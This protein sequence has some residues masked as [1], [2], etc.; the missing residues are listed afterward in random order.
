MGAVGAEGVWDLQGQPSEDNVREGGDDVEW[1]GKALRAKRRWGRRGLGTHWKPK[2]LLKS[3]KT[4]TKLRAVGAVRAAGAVGAVGRRG[5]GHIHK[6]RENPNQGQPG[7]DNGR[8]PND[9][10]WLG[11]WGWTKRWG[12]VGGEGVWAHIAHTGFDSYSTCKGGV[13]TTAEERWGQ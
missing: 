6:R 13:R 2:K 4:R 11:R 7:R 9:I 3:L 8:D 5:F 1:V 10:E 12:A